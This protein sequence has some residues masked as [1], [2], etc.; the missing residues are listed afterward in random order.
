MDVGF[1]R[2]PLFLCLTLAFMGLVLGSDGDLDK[3]LIGAPGSAVR[4]SDS[5]PGLK[6]AL[7]FAEERYNMGSNAMHVRRVS[8]ILSASKQVRIFVCVY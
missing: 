2:C 6:K 4:L 8:K 7:K 1:L 3:P 5:D